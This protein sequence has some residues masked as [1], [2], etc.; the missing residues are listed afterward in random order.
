MPGYGGGPY[1]PTKAPK[2][3]AP[4][5]KKSP[6]PKPPSVVTGGG[7]PAAGTDPLSS[8]ISSMMIST[9][10]AKAQA[11]VD[12]VYA[13]QRQAI[14]D[15]IAQSAA[16]AQ[17]RASQ[18]QQVYAAFAQY[19]GG[20]GAQMANIYKTGASDGSA[21]TGMSGPQGAV[22]SH[23]AAQSQAGLFGDESKIWQSYAAAQPGI[24]SLTAT[25]N[26]KQMLNVE[27]QNE[28]ALRA[29][30]LDLSSQEASS[31]LTYLQD[32]Q[33]KDIQIK[34]W[35]YGAGVA[36]QNA[37]AT[38]AYNQLKLDEQK[39]ADLAKQKYSEFVQMMATNKFNAQQVNDQLNAKYKQDEL[40]LRQQ[41]LTDE[42][43]YRQAQ[44]NQGSQRIA[45]SRASANTA[46]TRAA[47]AAA[48]ARAAP[49]Q[50]A[51]ASLAKLRITMG[52]D[53]GNR[54]AKAGNA[55][56]LWTAGKA[57]ASHP[58]WMTPDGKVYDHQVWYGGPGKVSATP[59]KGYAKVAVAPSATSPGKLYTPQNLWNYAWKTYSKPLFT[60]FRSIYPGEAAV[61]GMI[62]KRV[63]NEL[64]NLTGFR[65]SAYGG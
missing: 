56:K 39:A 30:L 48:T 51:T 46:A 26:I 40:T 19:M 3:T 63:V 25:Q 16:N 31:I 50:K 22:G 65:P 37:K 38:A 15:Q 5:V 41:T 21:L 45:I 32:A 29:K 60:Y 33:A 35:G 47:T 55:V 28:T 11:L 4:V 18:M 12:Q 49:T 54:K 58:L 6:V 20:M 27:G 59:V 23:L 1:K 44:L 8:L 10:P 53:I 7:T 13:P 2:I 61:K 43:I 34:Q 14:N 42:N 62:Q 24:Y 9:D 52:K 57:T 17:A 64:A 36:Q